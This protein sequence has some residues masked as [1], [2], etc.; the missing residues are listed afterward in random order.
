M[1][2]Y[3]LL[4]EAKSVQCG[5]ISEAQYGTETLFIVC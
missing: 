5:S 4:D 3:H 1:E 2:L